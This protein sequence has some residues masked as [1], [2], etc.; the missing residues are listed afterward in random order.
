MMLKHQPNT[1]DDIFG[2]HSMAKCMKTIKKLKFK[3]GSNGCVA[4]SSLSMNHLCNRVL[5]WR[6]FLCLKSHPFVIFFA[7]VY[8]KMISLFLCR[9]IGIC[10]VE[11]CLDSKENLL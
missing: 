5:R 9:T 10:F 1:E 8:K 2:V 11:H 3:L 4:R 6:I 7:I